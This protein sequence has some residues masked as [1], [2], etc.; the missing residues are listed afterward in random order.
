MGTQT[1]NVDLVI[2]RDRDGTF[3]PALVP[4]G[5][6]RLSG[7][8]EMVISLYAGGMTVRD[9]GHHLTSTIGTELS[10]ETISNITDAIAEAILE[11]QARPLEAFY[12]VVYL[13]AIVVKVRDGTHVINKS[14]HI[15]VGVDMDGIKHV[16][17]IWIQTSEGAK[18]WAGV[19]AELANR[20]VRDV[21][22]VCCDGLTGLPEAIEA[23]WANAT[24]QTSSIDTGRWRDGL[25]CHRATGRG[26]MQTRCLRGPH[27]DLSLLVEA[28]RVVASGSCASSA[29]MRFQH[30]RPFGDVS[31]K[32][33]AVVGF[34]R[35]RIARRYRG[36]H[37]VGLG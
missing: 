11:W 12:P 18:F 32:D 29:V 30:G 2:P 19:C 6:R 10:H 25:A 20:G 23:T 34:F 8:D 24:V 36:V 28:G 35:N 14:A 26:P 22:I 1:G 3:T 7:L 16:L 9:I 17:G 5:S 33:R 21:L 27:A 31:G 37:R 4:K 13:D 15:A